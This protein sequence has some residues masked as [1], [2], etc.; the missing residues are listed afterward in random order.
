MQIDY[1]HQVKAVEAR[2][3]REKRIMDVENGMYNMALDKEF[4]ERREF[5]GEYSKQKIVRERYKK[6][7]E[8]VFWILVV[9]LLVIGLL[10]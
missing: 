9:G 2:R 6:R 8:I 1:Q 3:E 7:V 5:Q 4:M 10:N